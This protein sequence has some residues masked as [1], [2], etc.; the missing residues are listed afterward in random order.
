MVDCRSSRGS[1]QKVLH[2]DDFF[3]IVLFADLLLQLHVLCFKF[4]LQRADLR[5]GG[6][7]FRLGPLT[8]EFR[9]RTCG[10][11]LDQIDRAR[12]TRHGFVIQNGDVTYDAAFTIKHGHA[13]VALGSPIRESCVSREEFLETFLVVTDFSVKHFLTGCVD[14]IELEIFSEGVSVPESQSF[15]TFLII[16]VGASSETSQ[17]FS[18]SFFCPLIGGFGKRDSEGMNR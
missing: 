5:Q 14:D 17:C 2:S 8:L 6:L 1:E 9:G 13:E 16:A 10:K 7:E 12:I 18:R 15:C 4:F 3:K 11:N